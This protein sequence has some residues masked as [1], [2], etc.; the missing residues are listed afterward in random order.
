M[1]AL[2]MLAGCQTARQEYR[3]RVEG[4]EMLLADFQDAVR[5]AEGARWRVTDDDNDMKTRV[6][7]FGKEDLARLKEIMLR[8]RVVPPAYDAELRMMTA[9]CT[10]YVYLELLDAKGKQLYDLSMN[11]RWICESDLKKY[12]PERREWS[13]FDPVWYL[14]DADYEAMYA[15]FADLGKRRGI[16]W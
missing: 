6:I 9:Y 3:E 1:C 7:P 16:K 11:C 5:R 8:A 2:L 10:R 4:A 14:P 15:L 13:Y 12:P